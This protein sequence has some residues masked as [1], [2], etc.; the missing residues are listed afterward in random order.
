MLFEKRFLS[1]PQDKV[2]KRRVSIESAAQ[3]EGPAQVEPGIYPAK[4]QSREVRTR[5]THHEG[6]EDREGKR[7]NKKSHSKLR[8]PRAPL[9]KSGKERSLTLFE[10]TVVVISSEREKSFL[11]VFHYCERA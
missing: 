6:H 9:R 11:R 4:A 5:M 7:K 2:K 8:N 1:K 10:M 3:E